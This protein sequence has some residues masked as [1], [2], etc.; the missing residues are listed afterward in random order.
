MCCIFS[1]QF[2]PSNFDIFFP[3]KDGHEIFSKFEG[4]L[5]N[6]EIKKFFFSLIPG[7]QKP[8]S[9]KE[10]KC[11]AKKG[12]FHT[13]FML[14]AQQSQHGLHGQHGLISRY[15]QQ[16]QYFQYHIFDNF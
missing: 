15:Y 2:K 14:H 3:N 7:T 16:D 5:K 11:F 10:E 6:S 8:K 4:A 13:A 12:I 1:H 9:R